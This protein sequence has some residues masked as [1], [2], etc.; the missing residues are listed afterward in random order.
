[1]NSVTTRFLTPPKIKTMKKIFN[2]EDYYDIEEKVKD[3]VQSKIYADKDYKQITRG[4]IVVEIIQ[5]ED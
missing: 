5:D 1:M 2:I 3:Y 4:V